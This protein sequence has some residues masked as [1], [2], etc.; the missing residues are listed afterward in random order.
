MSD[1]VNP[2][3]APAVSEDQVQSGSASAT[4]ISEKTFQFIKKASP[5]AKFLGVVSYIGAG[6]CALFGLVAIVIGQIPFTA[7]VQNLS[8]T[9]AAFAG[10]SGALVGILY[11]GIGIML[12]FPSR[13]LYLLGKSMK[14]F[15]SSSDGS[16]LEDVARYAKNLLKFYGI[17]AIVVLSIYALALLFGLGSLALMGATRRG[18]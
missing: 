7:P 16:A 2:Y 11:I 1:A 17:L 18:F 12:F 10:V 8:G 15:K 6:F 14:N 5:W 3:Q 9:A 13:Y 4:V